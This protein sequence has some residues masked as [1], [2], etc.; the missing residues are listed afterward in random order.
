M[1]PAWLGVSVLARAAAPVK[2]ILDTDMGG[3]ACRD[4][5]DV[6]AL[7][8]LHAMMV[9]GLADTC[10][11]GP[12]T[13]TYGLRV[14]AVCV[15]H[16]PEAQGCLPRCATHCTCAVCVPT[17]ALLCVPGTV[18]P[19]D[20]G[21][22]ELLAV[23]QDTLPPPCAGAISVINHWYGRDDI[24]IGAYKGSGLSLVPLATLEQR[25]KWGGP[26]H[27]APG[28][29]LPL[30]YVICVAHQVGS[31]P[32]TYVESLVNNFPSPVRSSSQVP[33]A[34]AVERL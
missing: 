30:S 14:P 28:G 21:E 18:A 20:N 2:L 1:V 22:V 3:G 27:Y 9:N 19:Q 5:D 26:A 4:V 12:P 32:L 24:P 13:C 7:C 25:C 15:L 17:S 16:I 31:P 8:T 11:P 34:A 6:V 23:L 33:D 29:N 10:A